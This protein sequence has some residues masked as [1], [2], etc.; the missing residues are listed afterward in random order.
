MPIRAVFA[1]TLIAV[2]VAAVFSSLGEE[3]RADPVASY[4][5]RH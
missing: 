3:P 1:A 5:L 4:E 2:V